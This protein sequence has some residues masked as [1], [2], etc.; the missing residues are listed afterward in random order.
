[1]S[2]ALRLRQATA[3]PVP[4]R[5]VR[6]AHLVVVAVVVAIT[7]LNALWALMDWHLHDMNVYWSAGEQWR[8][9]GNPYTLVPGTT[10]NSVYRYAPWF[11]ALWVPLTELPR[12]LVNI[13]WSAIL[14][15]TSFTAVWPLARTGGRATFLLALLMWGIM[16]GMAAGGNVHGLMIAWLVF[17]AERRSG[18]LWIALA[19]SL[20]VVPILYV[21]VYAGRGQ[22][23]RAALTLLLTAALVAP[24]FLFERPP[25]A[26]EF[27]LSNSLWNIAPWLWLVAVPVCLAVAVVVAFRWNRYAWPTIGAVS[28]LVLPRLF[29]YD[30]T[31]LLPGLAET[32]ERARQEEREPK[33]ARGPT[34]RHTIDIA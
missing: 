34:D 10:D 9:T 17:G 26:S 16:F 30:V 28:N 27:G 12:L 15:V 20:K 6:T 18:P 2:A 31:F 7:I 1:M 14:V 33:A 3:T 13:G 24:M 22:W 32:V 21:L 4:K 29:I 8:L 5:L 19:A 11:A 23:G 25:L